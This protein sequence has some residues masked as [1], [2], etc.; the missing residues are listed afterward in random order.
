MEEKSIFDRPQQ[1]YNMQ[2]HLPNA[3]AVL[4]LGILS[5]VICFVGV[6]LGII[7]LVL[8]NKDSKL[9]KENPEAYLLGSYN[10]LKAG[11]TC[12]IIGLIL[13]ALLILVYAAIIVFAISMGTSSNIWH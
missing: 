10:N 11:R 1:S 13:N 8:A 6:V 2:Q 7:S 4:V 3:T 9:Y 12:A 5:L